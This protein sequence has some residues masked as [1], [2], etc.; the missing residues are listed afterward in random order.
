M[1]ETLP[2]K[3]F[4]RAR[5]RPPFGKD[6][7]ARWAGGVYAF[8]AHSRPWTPSRRRP[9]VKLFS[10]VVIAAVAILAACASPPSPSPASVQ[11]AAA[12]VAPPDSTVAVRDRMA[13]EVLATIPPLA[14]FLRGSWSCEGGT[15][16]GKT[17]SGET[18]FV[19]SLSDRWLESRHIDR[20]PGRYASVAEWPIMAP[21][22]NRPSMILYDN[23][24]GARRF[25]ASGWG[26]DSIV[27]V[28]DTTEAESRMETFTYR[29]QTDSTYWYAWHVR[30]A[31][32]SGPTV[33]GD[34][35]TCT[36]RR[37]AAGR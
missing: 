26:V 35:A 23:F 31:P 10:S 6:V 13:K 4:S 18:Q 8:G 27:W 20:S 14:A 5:C 33:L 17:L 36:R 30:R 21:A 7:T 37:S 28:R 15:P 22:S 29:R 1:A 12:R 2:S 19:S 3:R 34:S 25:F 16:A 11:P 9:A 32:P 24:G